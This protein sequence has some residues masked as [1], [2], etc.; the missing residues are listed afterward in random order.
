MRLAMEIVLVKDA[1]GG[2]K[3][4]AVVRHTEKVVFVCSPERYATAARDPT[5]Q[6]V[7]GVPRD[8]VRS[9]DESSRAKEKAALG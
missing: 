6:Y 9:A 3:R 1:G 2:E 7:V 8:D 5:D 4:L